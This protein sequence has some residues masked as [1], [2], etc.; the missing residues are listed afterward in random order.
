[1]YRLC[2][3]LMIISVFVVAGGC[4]IVNPADV[5]IS[6]SPAP[7]TIKHDDSKHYTPYGRALERV[8]RQQDKVIKELNK[9]KWEHVV[10]ETGD[11]TEQV[12]ALNGHAGHSSDP[13]KFRRY[14]EQLLGHT[15][16]ARNA[17]M[18][19][20]AA[21]CDRAIRACDPILN[22]FSRDYPVVYE[23]SPATPPPNAPPP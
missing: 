22:Q 15:Q 12:R 5:Q 7:F 1:M 20:D 10:D 19:A 23:R 21:G 16:A 4:V 9:G 6:A 13:P 11:W 17:A 3:L 8:I 18:R 14:C 2:Y